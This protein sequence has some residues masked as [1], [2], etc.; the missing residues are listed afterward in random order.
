MSVSKTK[1][2]TSILDWSPKSPSCGMGLFL[3][4]EAPFILSSDLLLNKKKRHMMTALLR[5]NSR[6]FEGCDEYH[7]SVLALPNH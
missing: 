5:H 4:S 6:R 3:V 2:S 7:K 1:P